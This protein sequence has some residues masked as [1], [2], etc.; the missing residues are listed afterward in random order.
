MKLNLNYKGHVQVIPFGVDTV[1][2]S[3]VNYKRA[4]QHSFTIGIVKKLERVYGIDLL[5]EAFI[6]LKTRLPG[7]DLRLEIYGSGSELA[8]LKQLCGHYYNETIFF[9]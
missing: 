1:L 5:I 4:N 9:K 7:V 6:K 8:K 2:F 3:A